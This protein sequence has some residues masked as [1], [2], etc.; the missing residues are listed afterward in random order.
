MHTPYDQIFERNRA[1]VRE[2]MARDPDY[3]TRL[4]DRQQE[5]H[6]LFIG[7][8]DSRVPANVITG[9]GAGEMFVHRNIANL[10]VPTDF[11]M[12]SVVQYAVDV[13][14]RE[15][16]HRM[17]APGLRRRA[18]SHGAPSD[19]AGGPLARPHPRRHPPPPGGA[20]RDL[21]SPSVATSVWSS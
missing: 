21:R 1:W 9:T 14:R 8:S 3:F 2:T 12:L 20:R 16:H 11:N 13:L 4:A 5:P 6:F 17:R 7:C 15:G 18:G 19:R 10:V